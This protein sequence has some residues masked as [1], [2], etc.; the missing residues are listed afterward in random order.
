M[1]GV[2]EAVTSPGHGLDLQALLYAVG[3]R[4]L[5]V[6]FVDARQHPLLVGFILIAAGINLAW[7]A[8]ESTWHSSQLQVDA[9]RGWRRRRVTICV[10]ISFFLNESDTFPQSAAAIC[11]CF[12]LTV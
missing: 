5:V 3:Q 7:N 11:T 1:L 8:A 4:L 6:V 12:H 2:S 9:T 10:S